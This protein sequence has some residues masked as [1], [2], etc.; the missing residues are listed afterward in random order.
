MNDHE[1]TVALREQR[2]RVSMTMPVE[3]IISRG[4]AVRAR[5][6]VSG[7][8]AT[9]GAAG[10][11]GVAAFTVGGA[12][13]AAHPAGS[14]PTGSGPAASRPAASSPVSIPDVRLAAW[15]VTRGSG[16]TIKVT[17]REAAD[18]ATLQATL[19]ADGVPVSVDFTGQPN[20]ACHAYALS[21]STPTPPGKPFGGQVTGLLG[22][23]SFLHNPKSAYTSP[24]ALT[25]NPSKLPSGA[26]VQIFTSGTPGGA[27][28]FQLTVRLVHASASCTG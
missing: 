21:G 27:D 18:A 9:L 13:P 19:R 28:N 26:G 5:R 7:A 24:Y 8:A 20:P 23:Y 12:V 6:R 14:Y 25:I 16:G 22:G 4:R 2:G 1:L 10:V 17:F 15:T 3:Q 11:A